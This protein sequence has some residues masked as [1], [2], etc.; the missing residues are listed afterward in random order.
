[1]KI[2]YLLFRTLFILP[3]MMIPVNLAY[4]QVEQ[5]WEEEGTILVGRISHIEGQLS[6][7]DP[8]GNNW[9]ATVK[10][11]PFGIDDLLYSASEAR[12]ELI[13]PNNTWARMDGDTQIQLVALTHGV[14][15]IDLSFGRARLYNKSSAAEVK[16]TTPFGHV[17]APA[18]ATFD[19]FV[20][21]GAVEVIALKGRV[22]FVH[23]TSDTRH[24]VIAGSASIFADLMQV[25]ASRGSVDSG[26]SDWNRDQDTLWAGRM[27]TKG[28]SVT[29]LPRSLH[30]DAYALD[31]HGRWEKVYYDGAYYHFWRPVHVSVGWAPFTAGAWTIWWGDHV[32]IPHEPFGYVT[33]HYGNWIFTGGYWY[34]APPVTRVMIHAG[35]PLLKIGFGWYPGR[36]AWIHSGVHVGWI[37]LA[38]FEPYYCHRPWGRRSIVVGRGAYPPYR[39]HR[40]LRHAVIIHRDHL[41]RGINYK[42]ARVR[43]ISHATVLKKFRTAP[44]LSKTVIKKYRTIQKKDRYNRMHEPR[45]PRQSVIKGSKTRRFVKAKETPHQSRFRPSETTR[46]KST[47]AKGRP[48]RIQQSQ[49]TVSASPDADKKSGKKERLRSEYRWQAKTD[50]QKLKN[51]KR[52]KPQKDQKRIRHRAPKSQKEWAPEPVKPQVSRRIMT[53]APKKEAQDGFI[54]GSAN[55]RRHPFIKKQNEGKISKQDRRLRRQSQQPGFQTKARATNRGLESRF[56]P[57]GRYNRSYRSASVRK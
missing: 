7:Y 20:D 12:A 41:Y 25:T 1:M 44:V 34:W 24:E 50:T 18:G 36:V 23:N 42:H 30:A 53:R 54:R 39:S 56:S 3:I 22:Y 46:I 33:H 45:K 57:M 11:A 21:E 52:S 29:Y 38:P 31:A 55:T 2:L 13:M 40:H 26:W 51:I 10:D 17:M 35:L 8:E 32:W 27:R 47:K 37:P 49:K 6:R 16:A 9:A 5:D 15:E 48:V 43:N 28:E 4:A 14:T 19:L